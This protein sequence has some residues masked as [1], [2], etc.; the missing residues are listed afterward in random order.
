M[1]VYIENIQA[2]V[3][4]LRRMEA[5]IQD[6]LSSRS[7]YAVSVRLSGRETVSAWQNEAD[8]FTYSTV[9]M[10]LMWNNYIIRRHGYGVREGV[11]R[12]LSYIKTHY[13]SAIPMLLHAIDVGAIDGGTYGLCYGHPHSHCDDDIG[14]RCILGWVAVAI[15][16]PYRQGMCSAKYAEAVL[17]RTI[18]DAYLLENFIGGV[19][20]PCTAYRELM[21]IRDALIR[22][23]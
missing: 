1:S 17:A 20:P 10:S 18:P 11:F 2:E 14:S 12:A 13:A 7:P 21:D 6:R 15:D 3:L 22:G 5:E 19:H 16:A 8:E 4:R 23:K 9:E